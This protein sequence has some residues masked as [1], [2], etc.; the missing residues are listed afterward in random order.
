MIINVTPIAFT[1]VTASKTQR[2]GA[3][4][5]FLV[6]SKPKPFPESSFQLHTLKSRAFLGGGVGWGG[7][8]H[9]T[10]PSS[11]TRFLR[12]GSSGWGPFGRAE[13]ILELISLFRQTEHIPRRTSMGAMKG[14]GDLGMKD[15]W[16]EAVVITVAWE[17]PLLCTKSHTAWH[18]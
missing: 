11:S 17:P 4:I 2:K 15:G 8:S 5:S 10:H 16:E 9:P 3:N 7:S 13:G 14:D 1:A 18:S 12:A 6:P